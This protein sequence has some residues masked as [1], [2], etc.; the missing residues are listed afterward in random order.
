LAVSGR[1]AALD[2]LAGPGLD[3]LRRRIAP[4]SPAAP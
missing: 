1:R 2:D 4:S 3:V